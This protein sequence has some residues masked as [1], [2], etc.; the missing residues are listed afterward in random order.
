MWNKYFTILSYH[1]LGI[2]FYSETIQCWINLLQF[3]QEP[4]LLLLLH[5]FSVC[6]YKFY[7]NLLK[8]KFHVKIFFSCS[9]WVRKT[10]FILMYKIFN[11]INLYNYIYIYKGRVG[12]QGYLFPF[13][14]KWNH[15]ESNILFHKCFL[16]F[17]IKNTHIERKFNFQEI[18]LNLDN[19]K[20]NFLSVG[21]NIL[22]IYT[23]T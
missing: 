5:P 1:K 12:I 18:I 11:I 21:W 8:G 2:S 14:K 7:S 19:F 22:G 4:K 6:N 3:Q 13:E 15:K 16:L 10:V 17:K 23:K 9:I 20:N